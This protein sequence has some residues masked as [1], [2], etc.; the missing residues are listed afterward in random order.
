MTSFHARCAAIAAVVQVLVLVRFLA[1]SDGAEPVTPGLFPLPSPAAYPTYTL[2]QTATRYWAWQEYT[3]PPRRQFQPDPS[4]FQPSPSDIL[5]S[6]SEVVPPQRSVITPH[7]GLELPGGWADYPGYPGGHEQLPSLSDPDCGRFLYANA[8][9]LTP[10]ASGNLVT[11]ASS[12]SGQAAIEMGD[13]FDN[14]W[15]GGFEIGGGW[16]FGCDRSQGLEV[17]YWGLFAAPGTVTAAGTLDSPLDFSQLDYGGGPADA[18]FNGAAA[19]RVV[20]DQNFHSVEIN[21]LGNYAGPLGCGRGCCCDPCHRSKLGFG[22]LAGFR[23]INFTEDWLLT[24]DTSEAVFDDDAT[25]LGYEVDLDNNLFGFQ[26]GLGLDYC[27]TPRFQ[28]YAVAK[29]GVYGNAINHRQQIS[30]VLGSA[31]L[32][33]GP[34]AGSDY[35]LDDS[36]FDLALAGQLDLGGRYAISRRWSVDF[37]YRLVGLSGVATAENNVAQASLQSLAGNPSTDTS[38]SLILHGAYVGATC[39]W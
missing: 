25:E 8:L 32:N 14:V 35:V 13:E 37:G 11:S 18:F 34:Q 31:T 20:F 27:L 22:W 9:I 4:D 24:A 10:I 39:T 21:V 12:G 38:G 16:C 1:H 7:E 30:G 23:Y 17:V 36:D 2:A 33:S 19:H 3:Q 28:A 26:M 29:F 15:H 6:P 5:P